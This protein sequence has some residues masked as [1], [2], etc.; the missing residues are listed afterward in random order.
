MLPCSQGDQ[1]RKSILEKVQAKQLQTIASLEENFRRKIQEKELQ[2]QDVTKRNVDLEE[3]FRKLNYEVGMWQQQAKINEDRIAAL[4]L[5]YQQVHAQNREGWGDSE[6]D[7][8]SC[9]KGPMNFQ[10]LCKENER[11]SMACKVCR[12]NEMC[13][14][15][16]PCRHLC[17]CKDCEVKLNF[18]PVCQ[19][20]KYFGVEV[21][22]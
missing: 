8:I 20:S 7:S 21:Y 3:Q 13:M 9:S 11:E 4:Q 6:V 14:L 16:L 12:V 22:M 2:I 1:L 17:L 5:K 19:S 10:L 18:C 15:L